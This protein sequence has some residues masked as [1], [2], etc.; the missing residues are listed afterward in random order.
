MG[1]SVDVTGR[2]R[3]PKEVESQA[4]TV[5]EF[6]LGSK[7][8]A[9]EAEHPVD[10]FEEL[11]R[12][13]A[14]DVRRDGEW[15]E[16]APFTAGSPGWSEQ[17]TAFYV[18]LHRW[19]DEGAVQVAGE[20]GRRWSYTY[21]EDGVVRSGSDPDVSPETPRFDLGTQAGTDSAGAPTDPTTAEVPDQPD[22]PAEPPSAPL[23]TYPG[24]KPRDPADEPAPA[25]DPFAQLG[26][27]RAE[28]PGHE[29]A[30]PGRRLAM[31]AALI[32]GVLLIIGLAFVVSGL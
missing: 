10:S 11:A 23:F 26:R 14:A 28:D 4:L 12:Y 17:A 1:Y 29:P 25:A 32:V 27:S 19:V 15:L 22:H 24:Q 21:A 3:L 31:T 6:E 8:G 7:Q 20:D 9:F 30:P 2:L 16:L 5:L 18:G 13:A